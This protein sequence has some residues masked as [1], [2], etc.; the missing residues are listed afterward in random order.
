MLKW[1]L[2]IVGVAAWEC[3]GSNKKLRPNDPLFNY[4]YEISEDVVSYSEDKINKL[5][6]F[7][8]NN[9]IKHGMLAKNIY[10]FK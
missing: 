6:L 7:V 2:C 10:C 5:E 8:Q 4:P 1:L 3:V 9:L